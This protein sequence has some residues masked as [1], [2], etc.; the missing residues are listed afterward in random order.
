MKFDH[1]ERLENLW[2][3]VLLLE[4][5]G[6][7]DQAMEELL[8]T[9][10]DDIYLLRY[11]IRQEFYIGQLKKETAT[12]LLKRFM[13]IYQTKFLELLYLDFLGDFMNN[14]VSRGLVHQYK[15]D[16]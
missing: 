12:K 1:N 10:D 16:I 3:K 8:T 7:I 9:L 15:P 14:K 13:Q 11:I 4:S 5:S 2:C 6:D